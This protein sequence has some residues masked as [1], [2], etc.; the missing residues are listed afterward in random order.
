MSTKTTFKRIALVTVA[1]LGFGVLS[2]V[3][4]ASAADAA[5]TNTVDYAASSIEVGQDAVLVMHQDFIGET[6]TT[7]NSLT[8][9]VTGNANAADTATASNT[10]MPTIIKGSQA[11]T[12]VTAA[13]TAL[14]A[15]GYAVGAVVDGFPAADIGN[16]KVNINATIGNVGGTS[17]V[18]TLVTTM[19]SATNLGP[20]RVRAFQRIQWKPTVA[21][22][23]QL[24]VKSPDLQSNVSGALSTVYV[25]N[26]TV[27]AA[28]TAAAAAA[29]AALSL[30]T[31]S[32][33]FSRS[34]IGYLDCAQ[35]CATSICDTT[36]SYEKHA[37]GALGWSAYSSALQTTLPTDDSIYYT[38]NLTPAGQSVQVA[39][40]IGTD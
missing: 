17:T 16:G 24:T 8:F 28:G 5:F 26:F 25:W 21:G 19:T 3:A 31:P 30:Q 2:S 38:K 36:G 23:Y 13:D 29:K 18:A 9:V 39:G 11:G 22:T 1:A 33:T 10:V 4:P 20:A 37:Y 34:V 35:L 15:R 27:N 32:A 7:T 6:G 12:V 14:I 40:I